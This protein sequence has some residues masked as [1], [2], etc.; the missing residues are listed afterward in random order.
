MDEP[1]RPCGTPTAAPVAVNPHQTTT[2]E[3]PLDSRSGLPGGRHH[4]RLTVKE[5]PLQ[6]DPERGDQNMWLV[7]P[8][9]VGGHGLCEPGNKA[10][11]GIP[12]ARWPQTPYVQVGPPAATSP[13]SSQ[14]QRPA[15]SWLLPHCPGASGTWG[16]TTDKP[17]CREPSPHSGKKKTQSVIS[18]R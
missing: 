15:S 14:T 12:W 6:Q 4:P 18:P 3:G 13:A 5:D 1:G 10:E 8:P 17:I 2:G 7:R 16:H 9:P 11:E